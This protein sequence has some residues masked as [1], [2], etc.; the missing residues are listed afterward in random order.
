[1]NLIYELILLFK[2][3]IYEM[4]I[5]SIIYFFDNLNFNKDGLKELKNNGK[6][7]ES[8]IGLSFCKELGCDK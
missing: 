2:S 7:F 3:K 8:Y 6:R 5:K 1:M 4:D